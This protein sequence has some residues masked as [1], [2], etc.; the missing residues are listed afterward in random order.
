MK[1]SSSG[2]FL[3]TQQQTN[4]NQG[5]FYKISDQYSSKTVKII[6][7]KENPRNKK[8]IVESWQAWRED[9]VKRLREEAAI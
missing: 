1:K 2:F 9:H 6:K 5:T 4:P 7:N 8:V 3:K